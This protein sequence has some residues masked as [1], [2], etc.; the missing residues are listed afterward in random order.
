MFCTVQEYNL[1]LSVCWIVYV[2]ADITGG[3]HLPN[4]PQ[5]LH[6]SI[7]PSSG[8]HLSGIALISD[9]VASTTPRDAAADL[10]QVIDSFKSARTTLQHPKAIFAGS[11]T[12]DRDPESLVK[13]TAELMRT[14]RK[15]TPLVHQVSLFVEYQPNGQITN[16]VVINDSANATLAIGAS[17]IMATQPR[18]CK[19]L[20]P[21]I[22]ALLINFGTITDKEGML[23]AGREANVNRKPLVFDPVAVGATSYRRETSKREW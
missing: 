8:G 15:H 13:R 4:L 2:R 11:S 10:R 19:D 7:G 18:D 1:W 12:P 22:G 20:S 9:I 23:V 21:A 5:L 17:P 6:A 3:I 16:N 14:V